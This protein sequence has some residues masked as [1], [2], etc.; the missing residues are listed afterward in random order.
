MRDLSQR[1]PGLSVV[2]RECSPIETGLAVRQ[3]NSRECISFNDDDYD[4]AL[5]KGFRA[6]SQQCSLLFC[7]FCIGFPGDTGSTGSSGFPG[8]VGFTGQ[9]GA[10]GASGFPGIQGPFGATGATGAS[11]LAGIPGSFG[12]RGKNVDLGARIIRL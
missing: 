1:N 9:S 10:T 6:P 12:D 11:G 2:K 4:D 5:F 3:N 8:N 7:C